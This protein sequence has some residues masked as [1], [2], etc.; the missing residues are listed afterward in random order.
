MQISGRIQFACRVNHRARFGDLRQV[1]SVPVGRL[2]DVLGAWSLVGILRR[3][4][5]SELDSDDYRTSEI[6]STTD[7]SRLLGSRALELA[8]LDESHDAAGVR[9][10]R[11][12]AGRHRKDLRR[13][14]REI[15]GSLTLTDR[16]AFRMLIA[17]SDDRDGE[18]D[19]ISDEDRSVYREFQELFDMPDA[20]L[21]EAL[22][23]KEP[24]LEQVERRFASQGALGA[25]ATNA[26]EAILALRAAIGVF[27]GPESSAVD[28]LLRTAEVQQLAVYALRTALG[29]EAPLDLADL[30]LEGP[31]D[32]PPDG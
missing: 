32:D 21:L 10:L 22:K 19:P 23:E 13:A 5:R 17:A 30:P 12:L 16:R 29:I 6:Y 26:E 18:L 24:R 31:F 28:P 8:A 20:A 1:V 14:A 27:V 9:E 11:A 3:A 2:R 4:E 7:R 25:T 15:A